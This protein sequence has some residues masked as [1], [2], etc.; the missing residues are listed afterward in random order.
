M[1]DCS[2]PKLVTFNHSLC[3]M[4]PSLLVSMAL[5]M[6]ECLSSSELSKT[7][8]Y[9]VWSITDKIQKGK[10]LGSDGR[11]QNFGNIAS[12]MGSRMSMNV[13]CFIHGADS[14]F[15]SSHESESREPDKIGCSLIVDSDIDPLLV[16]SSTVNP[17]NDRNN[18]SRPSI[19]ND[20]RTESELL[21]SHKSCN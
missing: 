4:Y 2:E 13:N 6:R 20:N 9:L 16:G 12:W 21:H 10:S 5:K 3:E 17:P 14:Y 19:L 1:T 18:S 15:R 8:L 11:H 7:S